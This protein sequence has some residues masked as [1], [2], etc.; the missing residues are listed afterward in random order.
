MFKELSFL[1][2]RVALKSLFSSRFAVTDSPAASPSFPSPFST[3]RRK[4]LGPS[5]RPFYAQSVAA[6]AM[7]YCATDRCPFLGAATVSVTKYCKDQIVRSSGMLKGIIRIFLN[8]LWPVLFALVKEKYPPPSSE[9]LP[10]RFLSNW[11]LLWYVEVE[12]DDIDSHS[13]VGRLGGRRSSS[14][15]RR[16][17]ASWRKFESLFGLGMRK[18]RQAL[19]HSNTHMWRSTCACSVCVS[20][21]PQL[22]PH[23][24]RLFFGASWQHHDSLGRR[25]LNCKEKHVLKTNCHTIGIRLHAPRCLCRGCYIDVTRTKIWS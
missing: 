19:F 10:L 1:S 11:K 4:S 17:T 13:H 12:I 22:H 18:A 7:V 14:S 16:R 24:S 6:W 15:C 21:L 3:G 8:A 2:S 23:G 9:Q 20:S 5:P 25:E